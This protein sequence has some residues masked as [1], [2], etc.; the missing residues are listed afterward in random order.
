MANTD[1][2]DFQTLFAFDGV[3]GAD[4]L[5]GTPTVVG[6]TVFGMTSAGGD[7]GLGTIFSVNTDGT[8]FQTLLSFN[9][10]NGA[11][12]LGSLTQVGSVLY[13]VTSQGGDSGDGVLFS[14][15]TDGTDFQV[16][17]SFNGY[18][19][20]SFP[21]GDLLLNGGTLYGTTE[22]GGQNGSGTVFAFVVPEPST[23]ILVIISLATLVAVRG[24]LTSSCRLRRDA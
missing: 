6:S 11:D 8:D 12:P 18:G 3:H 4:P 24:G 22:G 10:A 5:Y 9:G 23:L 1:G 17:M 19:N 16:L 15:H 7:S 13:G 20:G 2:T 14:I 21:A